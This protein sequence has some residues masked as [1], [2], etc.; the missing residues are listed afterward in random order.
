[1]Y[2]PRPSLSG[3]IRLLTVAIIVAF[4]LSA[5]SMAYSAGRHSATTGQGQAVP[6]GSFATATPSL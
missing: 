2:P 5:V 4:G 6:A 3:L 1:M